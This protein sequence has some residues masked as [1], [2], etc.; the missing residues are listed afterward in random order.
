MPARRQYATIP[1]VLTP[2]DFVVLADTREQRPWCLDPLRVETATLQTG[3]YSIRGL[4][5]FVALERK[6]L[7]DLIGC[8]GTSRERFERELQRLAAYPSRAVVVEASWAQIGEGGW[9]GVVSPRVVLSSIASW[10]SAG[11]PF[12]LAGTREGA[13]DFAKGFLAACARRA[14]R[15]LRAFVQAV[16]DV[17]PERHAA[18][19][20]A[21]ADGKAW[22]RRLCRKYG[23]P[24]VPAEA[25]AAVP[26]GGAGA[27]ERPDQLREGPRVARP[28]RLDA[29]LAI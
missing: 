14:H 20:A 25:A 1:K 26:A 19:G 5:D 8:C 28:E 23:I 24:E 21:A 9:P 29:Q 17:R 3:D 10:T 4:T 11:I 16:A 27:P 13:Q 18:V 2:A 22:A 7:G 12:V 6:S 15:R